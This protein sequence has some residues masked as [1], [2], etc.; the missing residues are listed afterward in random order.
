MSNWIATRNGEP[1][2]IFDNRKKAVIWIKEL[3]KQ[4]LKDLD[5]QDKT[6]EFNY[7]IEIPEYKIKEVKTRKDFLGL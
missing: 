4:T 1:C 7:Q 2:G 5:K 6:N 3:L